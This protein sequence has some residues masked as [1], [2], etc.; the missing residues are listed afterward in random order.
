MNT[1]NTNKTKTDEPSQLFAKY[2]HDER[3]RTHW[4][5]NA[6]T[7]VMKVLGNPQK[8]IKAV[9]VTGTNG[10]G[11]TVAFVESIVRSAGYRTGMYTS[12]HLIRFN[13][14]IKVNNKEITDNELKKYYYKVENAAQK[15]RT[16]LSFF[17]VMTAIAFLYF[18]E[19]KV[20]LAVLEVGMGGIYDATNIC[21]SVVTTITSI[22]KEHTAHLGKTIESIAKNK[23]GIIKENQVCVLPEREIP[24]KAEQV[25]RHIA[26]NQQSRIV[27]A[28]KTHLLLGLQGTFQQRN[29]GVAVAVAQELN[30]LG[31]KI[32]RTAIS[33]GLKKT[34]WSG[35]LEWIDKKILVDGAHNPEGLKTIILEI[36]RIQKNF[37]RM[38]V[39]FGV[40]KDKEYE[41]MLKKIMRF[42]AYSPHNTELIL[43][44]PDTPRACPV[45]ELI[46]M[47]K[48][49]QQKSQ[50][51]SK[52]IHKIQITAEKNK[53]LL[54][55]KLQQKPKDE[56]CV[57]LGSL[58]LVG[59]IKR[60]IEQQRESSSHDFQENVN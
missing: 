15:T 35:R 31:F 30:K 49:I 5:L 29:G 34:Y 42:M 36:K 23:A 41:K 1:H 9:H 6:I 54:W 50:K 16:Q 55:E 8:E 53:K 37:K 43:T 40:L 58:Y 14:R 18:K 59:D 48:E 57:I 47:S 19:K 33:E 39:V 12:P 32:S 52:K 22:S 25:I 45:N 24:K 56:L 60:F 10:K 38:I 4:D 28:K 17:E 44:E 2:L 46:N 51:K 26:D 13:E 20:N 3:T 11:S 7:T 27:K 21:N